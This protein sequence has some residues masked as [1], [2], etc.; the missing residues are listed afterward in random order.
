MILDL[1]RHNQTFCFG[2]DSENLKKKVFNERMTFKQ[3]LGHHESKSASC[4]AA[5]NV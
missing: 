4:S 5:I 3:W 1:V 2:F